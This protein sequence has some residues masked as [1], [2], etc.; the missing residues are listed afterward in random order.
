MSG[1][2]DASGTQWEHCNKCGQFIRLDNLGY[3]PPGKE[4][5]HG[6]DIC[7]ACVQELSQ[8]QMRKVV[9]SR[10]WKRVSVRR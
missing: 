2:I 10:N 1:V 7:L 3:L 5:P 6:L 9:P 4:H 8:Y